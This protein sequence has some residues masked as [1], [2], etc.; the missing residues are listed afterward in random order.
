MRRSAVIVTIVAALMTAVTTARGL[1][2]T[3]PTRVSAPSTTVH[4]AALSGIAARVATRIG[5]TQG[6]ALFGESNG[7]LASDLGGMRRAG[8]RWLAVDFDWAATEQQRGVNDWSALDRVVHAAR[9]HGLNVVAIVAYTPAWA[10]P[11]HTNDKTPP[12]DAADYA[13]FAGAAAKRYAPLGVHDFQIWN[14]PNV[15]QF[16]WPHPNAARY[17]RLLIAA[18][19]AIHAADH[20]AV[21][22]AG[23]LAPAADVPWRSWSPYTFLDGMYRAGAHGHLDALAMHPYSFP[24]SPNTPAA[25]NPVFMARWAHAQMAQSGDGNRQI[26]AT[27]M[28]YGTGADGQSVSESTQAQRVAEML[29]AWAQYPFAGPS[30]IYN[31]RDLGTSP[32]VWDHMGLARPDG[33]AKPALRALE[34]MLHTG[35]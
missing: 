15:M 14:E 5:F 28:G 12:I 22:I 26:W 4:S 3:P 17:T 21:V 18:Y 8:A 20:H 10:R 6:A 33:S 9:A 25:W 34:H 1:G 27:E 13:R 30:L 19:A 24:W 7:Q 23:G 2:A 16:W 32:S 29:T 31:Y 11:A 35:P